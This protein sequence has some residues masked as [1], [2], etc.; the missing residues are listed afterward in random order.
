MT[1][2]NAGSVLLQCDDQAGVTG[3]AAVAVF[4]IAEGTQIPQLRR[5]IALFGERVAM[6][7]TI[8]E[9]LAVVFGSELF[10]RVARGEVVPDAVPGLQTT[11]AQ[12][13]LRRA[14]EAL[15]RAMTALQRG[16][17]GTFGERIREV[18]RILDQPERE[19]A[20]EP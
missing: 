15:E 2:G 6:E 7:R 10:E 9:A 11:R 8:D 12:Q 3:P 19:A 16:D 14:R 20:P 5:V 13:D 18:Q 17:F 1:R 4:L